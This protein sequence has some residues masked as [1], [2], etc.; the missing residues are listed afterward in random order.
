MELPLDTTAC[1]LLPLLPLAEIYFCF[2]LPV[3][4]NP[5]VMT[6]KLFQ[7]CPLPSELGARAIAFPFWTWNSRLKR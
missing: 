7:S 1:L 5:S 3:K 2:L 6:V 4:R